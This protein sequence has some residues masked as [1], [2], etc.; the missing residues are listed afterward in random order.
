MIK[1]TMVIELQRSVGFWAVLE[2][3]SDP[4]IYHEGGSRVPGTGC[5]NVLSAGKTT[6]THMSPSHTETLLGDQNGAFEDLSGV[7]LTFSSLLS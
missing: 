2:L 7:K 6:Y 5:V 1:Q 4:T 3:W